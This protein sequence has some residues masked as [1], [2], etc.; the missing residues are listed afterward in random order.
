M[1]DDTHH[2][3]PLM[4]AVPAFASIGIGR[5]KAYELMN[6][7]TVPAVKLGRSTFIHRKDWDGFISKL[8]AYPAANRCEVS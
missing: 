6:A 3:T 5:T 1:E 7:G 8:P 4:R 2:R